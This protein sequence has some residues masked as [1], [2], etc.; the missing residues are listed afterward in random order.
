MSY[1]DQDVREGRRLMDDG[2]DNRLVIGDKL[3][4]VTASGGDGVFDRY[5]DEISLNPRTARQYRHTA[6]MCTRPVRQLVADSGVHV[7]YSALREGARLAPSGKPYDE[8][9]STLRSLLK[10]A[11]EAGAGRVS[12][13][14]YR[15]ALGMEPALQDLLDPAS[16]TTLADYLDS[17]PPEERDQA[18]RDLVEKKEKVHDAL[19]RVMD[20]KRRRDRETRGPECGGGRPDKATAVARDLVRLSDQGSAFMSRYP[21]SAS[22]AFTDEQ[23]VACKEVLGTLDVLAT[24]IRVRILDDQTA[25]ADRRTATRDLVGV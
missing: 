23:K 9:Y 20:E 7:S 12:V 3:L 2:R 4:S 24:W 25:T 10:E 13:P 1:T 16:D 14:Q 21:P 6:R 22:L 5:C 15:R 8:S 18:L 17:L 11:R 19:K